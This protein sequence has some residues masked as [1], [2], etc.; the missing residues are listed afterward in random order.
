[1]FLVKEQLYVLKKGFNINHHDYFFNGINIFLKKIESKTVLCLF[2]KVYLASLEGKRFR[3]KLLLDLGRKHFNDID[4]YKV[5][6]SYP[7]ASPAI[8]RE[9][10]ACLME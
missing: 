3:N 6:C 10:S 4:V 7:T 9:S 2:T 8:G 5:L 1:M